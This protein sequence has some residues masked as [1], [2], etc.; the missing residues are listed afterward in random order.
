M[1]VQDSLHPLL[2]DKLLEL[3]FAYHVLRFDSMLTTL[4]G[5]AYLPIQDRPDEETQGRE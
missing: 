3:R 2:H 5:R 4:D 1:F